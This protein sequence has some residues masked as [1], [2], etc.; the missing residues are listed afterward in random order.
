MLDSVCT[1]DSS[2]HIAPLQAH[3]QVHCVI[4][5]V[6]SKNRQHDVQTCMVACT[7]SARDRVGSTANAGV[8]IAGG[9][10]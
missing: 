1:S 7:W 10:H 6:D 5:S 2:L 3:M 9:S 4:Q 8:H